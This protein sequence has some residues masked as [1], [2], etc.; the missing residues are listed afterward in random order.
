MNDIL[1]EVELVGLE[2]FKT[3]EDSDMAKIYVLEDYPEE[4]GSSGRYGKQVGV[5]Y[6]VQVAQVLPFANQLPRKITMVKQMQRNNDMRDVLRLIT[7]Q[8]G[9]RTEK[10]VEKIANHKG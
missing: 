4:S 8:D 10:A 3:K 9:W 2:V 6:V 5:D 1:K 7:I